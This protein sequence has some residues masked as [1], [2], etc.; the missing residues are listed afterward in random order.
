MDRLWRNRRRAWRKIP[1]RLLLASA[2]MMSVWCAPSEKRPDVRD[3]TFEHP[4]EEIPSS[5]MER[6]AAVLAPNCAV[7]G[8]HNATTKE[9]GM[10]LSTSLGIYDS[11]VGKKGIDHCTNSLL[12]RVV[13]GS[14]AQSFLMAKIGGT[15]LCD[16]S[17]PMPPPPRQMLS[18]EQ[19]ETIGLW[20]SIGAP[21]KSASLDAGPNDTIDGREGEDAADASIDSF[22]DA[23]D[24][25]VID[26]SDAVSCD[27]VFGPI[28][29]PDADD[30]TACT[31][32]IPCTM[33]E[34]CFG[35]ACDE[36]W[37]CVA[38][39]E[40]HPCPTDIVAYCGCDGVTFQAPWTCADRP[41]E[42]V[43][44]CDD[45]VNCDPSDVRC[46]QEEPSCE[47]GTVPS[48][49]NAVYGPCVPFAACRCEYIWECPH[50]EKYACDRSRW[51]CGEL[52]LD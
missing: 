47:P 13:P 44:A 37:E 3:A 36:R 2:A 4:I 17:Q 27:D 28:F 25:T 8:C 7:A 5:I 40:R 16:L 29:K 9:H 21:L 22:A 49:V 30:Q 39:R 52:P 46:S 23:A 42:H 51:R 15:G 32:N 33:G 14:S 26:V 1:P 11:L 43:G 50:R 19:I 41:F 48:V 35:L 31:A 20:I 6:V 38:H 34:I 10:D 24:D 18:P 12:V 45:G